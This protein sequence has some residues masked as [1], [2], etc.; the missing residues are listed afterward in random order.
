MD[1]SKVV[2]NKYAEIERIIYFLI[3]RYHFKLSE[4]EIRPLI[5]YLAYFNYLKFGEVLIY[6]NEVIIKVINTNTHIAYLSYNYND[7]TI[8]LIEEDAITNFTDKERTDYIY[9]SI[10]KMYMQTYNSFN[11]VAFFNCNTANKIDINEYRELIIPKDV[12]P[13]RFYSLNQNDSDFKKLVN[14]KMQID[15]LK[16]NSEYKGRSL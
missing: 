9:T 3:D 13:D 7:S 4:E 12:E 16:A 15:I 11:T 14:L 2:H 1:K 10:G 8:S 6:R 5:K